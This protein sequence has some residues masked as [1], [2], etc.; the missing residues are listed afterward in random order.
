MINSDDVSNEDIK[1]HNTNGYK[2]L[3][4]YTEY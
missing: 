4:I 2:L 3:I 1:E